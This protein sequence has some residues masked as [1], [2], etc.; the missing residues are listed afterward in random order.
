V[1]QF[2]RDSLGELIAMHGHETGWAHD[3][4]LSDAIA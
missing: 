4:V 1:D 2:K 3:V